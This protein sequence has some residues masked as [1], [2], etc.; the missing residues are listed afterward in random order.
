MI[1]FYIKV[2][3][4]LISKIIYLLLSLFLKKIYFLLQILKDLYYRKYVNIKVILVNSFEFVFNFFYCFLFNN[5]QFF[6]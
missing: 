6:C 4:V 3:C 5:V 2:N 1:V